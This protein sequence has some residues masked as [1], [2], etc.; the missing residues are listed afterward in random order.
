MQDTEIVLSDNEIHMLNAL[1]SRAGEQAQSVESLLEGVELSYAQGLS[2]L[3]YLCAKG[4]AESVVIGSEQ[5]R[6]LRKAGQDYL[7]QGLP[8]QRLWQ[9]LLERGSLTLQEINAYLPQSEAKFTIGMYLGAFQKASYVAFAGGAVTARQ[10]GMPTAIAQLQGYLAHVK[11]TEQRDPGNPAEG[12]AEKRKLVEDRQISLVGYRLTAAGEAQARL[13]ADDAML[14]K[15]GSVTREMLLSGAWRGHQF[16]PLSVVAPPEKRLELQHPL[17]RFLRYLRDSLVAA[18]FS[19]VSRPIL[20]TQF[21]NLNVLFMQKCHPVRSPRHLLAIDGVTLPAESAAMSEATRACQER[22]ALEYQ[23]KGTSGSRGWGNMD[24][25]NHDQV[26]A[27][28]HSTPV[29]VRQLA[30]AQ[31]YPVRVFGF[32]RCCRARPEKPEFLQMDVLVADAGLNVST[33]LGTI[34]HVCLAM[35]PKAVDVR[36]QANYFPFAEVSVD[37]FVVYA[38][39]SSDEIGSCGL[40]RPESAAILKAPVPV[41]L[42]GFNVSRLARFLCDNPKAFDPN[43]TGFDTFDETEVPV[44]AER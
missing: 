13:F 21:W 10:Q 19:E 35:F 28:S 42:I 30:T 43:S 27:R 16:R 18:G 3:G 37:I 39:G 17:P 23:G 33:L 11:E 25:F 41:G 12:E 38:D 7:E 4:L 14:D 20:E 24:G 26:V 1:A 36:V 15:I 29:T 34:K 31:A 6:V 5:K 2:A 22:F 32:S 40:L 9:H 44:Y 8:E